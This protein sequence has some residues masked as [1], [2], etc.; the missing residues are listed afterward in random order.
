MALIRGLRDKMPCP[1]CLIKQEDLWNILDTSLLHTTNRS[2]EII[3]K[4]RGERLHT[5][6][7]NILK[8]VGLRDIDVCFSIL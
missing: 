8:E 4:A 1:I 3:E 6:T 2:K 7:E 5:D